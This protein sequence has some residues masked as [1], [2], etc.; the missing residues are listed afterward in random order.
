MSVQAALVQGGVQ[1]SIMLFVCRARDQRT[2]HVS[3]SGT[4]QAGT[5]SQMCQAAHPS[6]RWAGAAACLAF[7][8]R[9]MRGSSGLPEVIHCLVV[10]ALGPSPPILVTYRALF[11]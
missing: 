10:Y 5:A 2:C 9:A 7:T 8:L 4:M 11:R 6:T 1:G 3:I